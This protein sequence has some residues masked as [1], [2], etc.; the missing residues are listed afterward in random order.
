MYSANLV[1][2]FSSWTKSV[3]VVAVIPLEIVQDKSNPRTGLNR[4]VHVPNS[5]S[6]PRVKC[7][8]SFFLATVFN[9]CACASEFLIDVFW[10]NTKRSL[11]YTWFFKI[12]STW[13]WSIL[14]LC[15][16][17][18]LHSNAKFL[19]SQALKNVKHYVTMSS[20]FESSFSENC[21]NVFYLSCCWFKVL[22]LRKGQSHFMEHFLF[23]L[24]LDWSFKLAIRGRITSWNV[25]YLNCRW[26][27]PLNLS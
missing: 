25:L 23:K 7:V 21:G 20:I 5:F 11:F 26:F 8:E 17:V 15:K 14:W 18:R 22:S 2:I 12:C 6:F 10:K 4:F 1:T 3:S 19:W 16:L 27:E 9:F 24:L 13:T